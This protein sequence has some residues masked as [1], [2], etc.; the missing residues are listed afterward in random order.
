MDNND[1]NFYSPKEI[2]SLEGRGRGNDNSRGKDSGEA[3][4]RVTVTMVLEVVR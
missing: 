1:F 3:R 2:S 4:G